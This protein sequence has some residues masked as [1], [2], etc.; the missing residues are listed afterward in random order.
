MKRVIFLTTLIL[1]AC[2]SSNQ[3]ISSPGTETSP[4]LRQVSTTK[5]L[6]NVTSEFLIS[7]NG[8]GKA[9]LGMTLGQLKQKS[10]H[11]TEFNVIQSFTADLN[12]ISVSKHGLVQYYILYEVDSSDNDQEFVPTDSDLI[13]L[14]MTNNYN[15]QTK[16]GIKVGTPIKEAEVI[17]GNAI[18]A[19][20]VEG[21]SIEYVS[22]G[23]YD[24]QNIR[25]RASYFKLISDGLGF[26]GIY[27]EYPGVTYTTDKYQSNAAIAAIE[28]GCDQK[29]CLK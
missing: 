25:F 21:E 23:D 22:F 18:L 5:S 19:Y 29:S 20:N 1:S 27:P 4:D 6:E 24:P 7:T 12:A 28:V 8:I 11:D 2:Q 10:D 15:Y 16:E 9:K 14:L 17:Y 13:T 26:A 3:L